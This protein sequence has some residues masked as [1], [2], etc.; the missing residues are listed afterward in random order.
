MCLKP[1]F[2]LRI[3][4][5]GFIGPRSSL[6]F[7]EAGHSTLDPSAMLPP[8]KYRGHLYSG[9]NTNNGKEISLSL[10]LRHSI[11]IVPSEK[12]IQTETRNS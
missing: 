2:V 7:Q 3:L 6:G 10:F 5:Y 11:R 12:R 1:L 9:L 8:L 4:L